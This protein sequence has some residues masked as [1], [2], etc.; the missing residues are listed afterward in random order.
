M[1]K[2]FLP[3]IILLLSLIVEQGF[4]Q[5]INIKAETPLTQNTG[6]DESY[7]NLISY[8]LKNG[9]T[10]YLNP[11]KNMT[12]VVGAIVVKGGAKADP[13]DATGIA[14]YLEHMLFKG[15]DKIGTIDYK[16]EKVWLDSIAFMYSMLEFAKDD[17]VYRNRIL[18]KVDYYSRRADKY[19]IPGEFAKAIELIGGQNL[20]AFTDFEKIVYHNEFP[21]KYMKEWLML[22]KERTENAVFRLFKTELETVFEEKN[23][24]QDNAYNRFYEEVYRNFYPNSV[25]GN[26]T[27]LGS[28]EHLKNPS[29]Y[30]MQ[31]YFKEH[32]QSQNMAIILVGNFNANAAQMMI[33]EIFGQF[34]KGNEKEL[35]I[36]T[37]LPFQGREEKTIKM[38]PIPM[39]VLGY[40]IP[41]QNHKDI[42]T[43]ELIVKLLHNEDN[44]GLLDSLN[45][46]DKIMLSMTFTHSHSDLGGFFIGFVPNFPVQS[47]KKAENQVIRVV[48]MIRE[49]NFSDS[50]LDQ[51]KQ[52][53]IKN[54][55]L[56]M[57]SGT[58]RTRKIAE[59]FVSNGNW[60]QTSNYIRIIESITKQDIIRIANNYLSDNYL[61]IK[62]KIGS[63]EKTYLQK[64]KFTPYKAEEYSE[65]MYFQKFL[66][67]VEKEKDIN[68]SEIQLKFQQSE[69]NPG[70]KIITVENPYNNVFYYKLVYYV[71]D[72]DIKGLSYMASY[73]NEVGTENL[74]VSQFR[75]KLHSLGTS[76][77]FR[78]NESFFII[79]IIGF[80]ENF[81]ESMLILSELLKTPEL[82]KKALKSFE[83]E[84]NLSNRLIKRDINMKSSA[85]IE[86]S[87]F[88][89]KSKYINRLSRSK[90]KKLKAQDLVDLLHSALNYKAEIMYSGNIK[91]QDVIN[92]TLA[93]IPFAKRPMTSNSPVIKPF[94]N[95]NAN[96]IYFLTDKKALQNKMS[97]SVIS[98]QLTFEDKFLIKPYN[99]FF[100][101]GLNS[102]VFKEIRE[103]RSLAY[104]ASGVFISPYKTGLPGLLYLST[105]TQFDKTP[106]ALSTTFSILD[107]LK[108]KSNLD[109]I[110]PTV[111]NMILTEIPNFRQI[112][113][114]VF[115]YQLQG[116]SIDPINQY[117]TFYQTMKPE[118]ITGF[119]Q[120]HI[121]NRNKIVT[122]VGKK[123]ILNFKE[124]GRY[125]TIEKVK[126]K[127][128]YVK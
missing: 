44:T 108:V 3:F 5:K 113:A 95:K 100:G 32:Y 84:R 124:L 128:L 2:I 64:P 114:Y 10:V 55:H 28:V 20:N 54:H 40:R 22:Y 70:V 88:G 31:T 79:D 117:L 72:Y 47:V 14:H 37:E 56:L 7:K 35:K 13:N 122:M 90:L 57:E 38:T 78:A 123:E 104:S 77:K 92:T 81:K 9:L 105:S 121:S 83:K 39:G 82:N 107:S 15:T 58:Y 41:G 12:K 127:K 50:F 63:P 93:N 109:Y 61:V 60:Q 42:P 27:V 62:S 106:E 111:N 8:K 11:D 16:S 45:R 17:T 66:E 19:A 68:L 67:Q 25:Y 48:N 120:S 24:S 102:V 53:A 52:Q 43:I 33:D 86:Y 4:S 89:D 103:Y 110:M 51:I 34:R 26:R 76:I 74:P 115:N 59:I 21:A 97:V 126:L 71:G 91:H 65:S 46:E 85:L 18:K 30:K 6:D 98:P 69:P 23:M 125:G 112:G 73:M 36:E 94:V 101:R 118:M 1:T 75:K 49:G 99:Y 87:L 119:H 96:T 80:D 116:F 29:I